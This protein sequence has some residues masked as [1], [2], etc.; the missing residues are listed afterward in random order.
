MITGRNREYVAKCNTCGK[1]VDAD[2]PMDFGKFVGY[3]RGLGWKVRE[4]NGWWTHVC[5][6]CRR[7]ERR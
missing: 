5:P 4:S 6:V 1:Q 3:I 7:K 2:R